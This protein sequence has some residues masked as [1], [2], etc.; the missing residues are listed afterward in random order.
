MQAQAPDRAGPSILPSVQ[1]LRGIAAMMVVIHHL[2]FHTEWL[3]EKAG[4]ASSYFAQ[5]PWSFGIHIFFVISGFIMILT[6]KNF[7]APGAWKSF[8]LR[9]FVRIVPLYWILTT[10]MVVGVL[11]APR[12]LE[13][14]ADKWHYILSCYLFIP[15]LRAADDLRPILGQGWTLDYEMFFYV[16]F[17]FA[18]LWPRRIG[19]TILTIGF[20]ALAILG[21]NL[22]ISTPKLFTWTDGLILEFILGVHLGLIY[23]RGFRVGW[24]GATGLVLGGIALGYPEF[25]WP[26]VFSAGLPAMLIVGGLV[27]GP[28]LKD[29]AATR[30]LTILG[31][32]SYSIYLSHTIVLRPFRDVWVRH[33]DGAWSPVAFFVCG[34]AVAVVVG[35]AIHY[36]IERPLLRVM[37][38]RLRAPSPAPS[39]PVAAAA[40]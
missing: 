6:T 13:L 31:D 23:Q 11:M 32:A 18:I 22:D 26:A 24:L 30:W 3:R 21:R 12:S 17:A 29:I 20:L 15:V 34:I 28:Q 40:G 27:L 14:P 9:R 33:I 35:C 39:L 19:V 10:V 16:A 25:N 36:A 8:L 37:S 7:G 5:M 2:N 1:W 4:V 38:R